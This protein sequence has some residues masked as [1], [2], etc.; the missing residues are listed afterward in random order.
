VASSFGVDI[1]LEAADILKG[2]GLEA[3][4]VDLRS[5]KP[6]D[7]ETL[8]KSIKKTGRLVVVDGSWKTGG[9]AAEVAAIISEESFADLKTGVRRVTL[10]D[11]HAPSSRELEKQYY[12]DAERIAR[13]MQDS[14]SRE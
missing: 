10:P 2:I 4:I 7:A 9:V 1:S 14:V 11:H 6:I 5:A 12:W 8:K 13:A 3:E